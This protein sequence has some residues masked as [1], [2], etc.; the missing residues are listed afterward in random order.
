MSSVIGQTQETDSLRQ[1]GLFSSLDPSCPSLNTD[2]L[3]LK[4]SRSIK[5][6]NKDFE[7][8]FSSRCSTEQYE[9][10]ILSASYL[11]AGSFWLETV[12]CSGS[13]ITKRV[14]KLHPS[15]KLNQKQRFKSLFVVDFNEL[16]TY[17]CQRQNATGSNQLPECS[18]ELQSWARQF[19]Q[20]ARWWVN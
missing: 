8:I 2:K 20:Q 16:N 6:R 18:A 12:S 14:G 15:P 1:A 19:Y 5:K 9:T 13:I 17:S 3:T 10:S 4:M 7:T 11:L